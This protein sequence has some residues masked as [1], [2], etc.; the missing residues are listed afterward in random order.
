VNPSRA[1]DR[2]RDAE[3]TIDI[4]EHTLRLRTPG[5]A[6][7]VAVVLASACWLAPAAGASQLI[8]RD[9]TAVRLQVNGEAR[10]L[11][12]YRT[13][14]RTRHVL[15]WGAVNAI[16]PSETREQVAFRVDYSGGWR[17]FGRSFQPGFRNVCRP[18]H[19]QLA[20]LVAACRA[21]DGSYWALQRWQRGLRNY[22]LPATGTRDDWEL[23]LSHWRGPVPRLEVDIGWAYRRFHSL[24]GRYSWRGHP[25]HGFASTPAGRPLDA[26]G[27]N[28]YLDTFNSAYGRGWRRENGFLSHVGSGGFCYG[29]Y[30]H[31]SRPSGMGERYR[32]SVSGPG[33]LPDVFWAGAPPRSYEAA[34][35]LAADRRQAALLAN[36]R[37]CRSR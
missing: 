33:V 6:V 24:F 18:A 36:D 12:S 26:F 5:L 32:L 2:D 9:A 20:W 3:P 1:G 8:A 19:V 30:P 23:R 27:R 11:V 22:G 10:A 16:H 7:A 21:P 28:L 15:A 4:V 29:F 17:S 31:G 35:D 13:G 37:S 25:I 34:F 14:G